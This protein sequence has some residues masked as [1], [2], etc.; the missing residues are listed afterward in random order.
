VAE[1]GWVRTHVCAAALF[2]LGSIS[3]GKQNLQRGKVGLFGAFFSVCCCFIPH[4]AGKQR[5]LHMAHAL[6]VFIYLYASKKGFWA[7]LLE[8]QSKGEI[9]FCTAWSSELALEYI[10]KRNSEWFV[11]RI[12]NFH[13]VLPKDAARVMG[14]EW[15]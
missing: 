2:F 14:L 7:T 12:L 8:A 13:F 15:W 3:R 11:L 9:L 1:K 6:V 5:E 10:K 4:G